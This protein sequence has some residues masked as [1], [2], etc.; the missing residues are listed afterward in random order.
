MTLKYAFEVIKSYAPCAHEE[1]VALGAGEY[2]Q[3]QSCGE[4]YY[5][6][7]Q[8]SK[9]RN[10]EEFANALEAFRLLVERKSK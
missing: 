5:S 1:W 9:R 8:E 7:N 6:V 10:V 3:C 4:R 2:R